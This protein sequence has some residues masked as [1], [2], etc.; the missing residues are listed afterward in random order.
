MRNLALLPRAHL[1]LHLEGAMRPTTFADLAQA[2]GE[3]PV[4]MGGFAS[5]ADFAA[6]YAHA[7]Q[8]VRQGPRENLLRL[9]R[10]VVEDAAADGAVWVEPHLN[11]LTYQDDP[12]AAL[13]L[14]DT[15]IDEGRRAAAR[16]G[17]GF[18]LLL[19]ARRNA[20]PAQAVAT[21]RLAARRAA[22]GVVAFGLAGDEAHFPRSRSPRPSPSRGAPD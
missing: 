1:H 4:E 16:L 3:R 12:Q 19:F 17:I 22:D 20:D 7:A 11:P 15:V 10:E 6:L 18:G 13:D 9:V 2:R 8:L 21:A 14:L 5:F